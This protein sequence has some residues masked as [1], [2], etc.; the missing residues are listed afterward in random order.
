MV[1]LKAKPAGEPHLEEDLR[2]VQRA[3]EERLGQSEST[4]DHWAS[5]RW[6]NCQ[7]SLFTELDGVF[8]WS[9]GRDH[10]RHTL[11]L[12]HRSQGLST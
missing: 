1:K 4:W 8:C 3:A 9:K 2:E 5:L 7:L 10:V 12:E 6:Q 11:S